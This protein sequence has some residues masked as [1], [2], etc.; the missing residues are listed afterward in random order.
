[1]YEVLSAGTAVAFGVDAT[2][3][4]YKAESGGWFGVTTLCWPIL[5]FLAFT[6][7][8]DT[9]YDKEPEVIVPV[10]H[11]EKVKMVLAGDIEGREVELT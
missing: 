11:Q 5:Y 6:Q 10:D 4:N 8:S 3:P 9:N 2:A 7:V 1:M